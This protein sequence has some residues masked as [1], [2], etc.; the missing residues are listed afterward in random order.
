MIRRPPRSTPQQSSAASD[1]YK[2]QF[3]PSQLQKIIS[4]LKQT[5]VYLLVIQS[6]SHLTTSLCFLDN[7][8]LLKY[9]AKKSYN[10][11]IVTKY[12]SYFIEYINHSWEVR[13][14]LTILKCQPRN[15][16]TK[17]SHCIRS[18]FKSQNIILCSSRALSKVWQNST[19]KQK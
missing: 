17:I 15:T 2:R 1:V 7:N 11:L 6:T 4:G 19:N 12:T 13:S 10:T 14:I 3:E 5:S 16:K 18:F 8:F 9:F